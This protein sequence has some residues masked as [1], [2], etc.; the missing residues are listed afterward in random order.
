LK[1]VGII[2]QNRPPLSAMQVDALNGSIKGAY[3]DQ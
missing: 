3:F 2:D 1:Q